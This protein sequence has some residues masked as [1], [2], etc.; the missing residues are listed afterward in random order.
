MQPSF[1]YIDCQSKYGS[2]FGQFCRAAEANGRAP[3]QLL[4][5]AVC[6]VSGKDLAP[7]GLNVELR[8]EHSRRELELA[9]DSNHEGGAFVKDYQTVDLDSVKMSSSVEY[10]SG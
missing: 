5:A 6:R 3:P 7:D 1:A 10:H 2:C 9:R 4:R 8:V